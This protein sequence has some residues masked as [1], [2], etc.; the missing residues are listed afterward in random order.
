MT[1]ACSFMILH[2]WTCITLQ[3]STTWMAPADWSWAGPGL[4][5]PQSNTAEFAHNLSF[6]L[7]LVYFA[8]KKL[9]VRSLV[10]CHPGR[11]AHQKIAAVLALQIAQ[12]MERRRLHHDNHRPLHHSHRHGCELGCTT[13]LP[14]G[15]PEQQ[16][17]MPTLQQLN[18]YLVSQDLLSF[19]FQ[20]RAG[21]AAALM[22]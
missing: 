19:A 4:P 16:L 1:M 3:A 5:T 10:S 11:A 18:V 20:A 22:L 14:Y 8:W 13:S 6:S 15:N 7:L 2:S 12:A 21:F 17:Q 9:A